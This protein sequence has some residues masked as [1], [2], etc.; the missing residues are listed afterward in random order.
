MGILKMKSTRLL[1]FPEIDV[2][3]YVATLNDYTTGTEMPLRREEKYEKSG[4][5][6]SGFSFF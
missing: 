3:P 4:K 1:I 6:I 2:R 5:D